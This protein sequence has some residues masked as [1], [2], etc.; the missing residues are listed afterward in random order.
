M[1]ERVNRVAE[2]S[3][4][5]SGQRAGNIANV[6]WAKLRASLS[7]YRRRWVAAALYAE[8]SKLSDPELARRGM[9]RADLQRVVSDIAES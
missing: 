8:L 4:G 7:A 9:A 1:S 5:W 6:L 2:S 3:I